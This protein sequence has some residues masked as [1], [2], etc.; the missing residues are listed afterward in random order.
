M[1]PKDLEWISMKKQQPESAKWTKLYIPNP[2]TGETEE[3]RYYRGK[4]YWWFDM[5]CHYP[6]DDHISKWAMGYDTLKTK[7]IDTDEKY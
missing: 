2:E 3:V 1:V 7:I 4:F 5:A 6:I